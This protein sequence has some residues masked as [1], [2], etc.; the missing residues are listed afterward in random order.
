ME[1]MRLDVVSY[2][3]I[4]GVEGNIHWLGHTYQI[5]MDPAGLFFFFHEEMNCNWWGGYHKLPWTLALYFNTM[6]SSVRLH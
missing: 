5:D 6:T 3:I 4:Q 2:H 1:V